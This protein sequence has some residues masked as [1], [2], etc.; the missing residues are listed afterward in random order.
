MAGGT[1]A[2]SSR[3][4]CGAQGVTSVFYDRKMGAVIDIVLG[5]GVYKVYIASH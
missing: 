3:Y 1:K 5:L 4:L 2:G